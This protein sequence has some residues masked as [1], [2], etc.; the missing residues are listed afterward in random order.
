MESL[1]KAMIAAD[2][3]ALEELAASELSYG[4]STGLI[5]DKAAFMDEFIKGT[6]VFTSIS[7]TDQM[8][9]ISGD[10]AIVR[11]HLVADTKNKN[12]PGKAEILV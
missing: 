1:R 4:H 10:S 8:I 12:V 2:K 11:H 3:T 6:S 5:E 9:K 7:L